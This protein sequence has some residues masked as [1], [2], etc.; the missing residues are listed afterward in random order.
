LNRIKPFCPSGKS[1]PIFRNRVKPQNQ[2]YFAFPEM[3]IMALVASSRP[4]RGAF[5][6]RH[7]ALGWGC[8]GRGRRQALFVPDE[9][10]SAYGEVVWSWR[11]D[12]GAKFLRSKLLRGDGGNKARSPGRARSK[13]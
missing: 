2:K 8:D 1:L 3:K 6:D 9:T 5:R 7:D 13:P 12:A 10:L 11:R 4:A